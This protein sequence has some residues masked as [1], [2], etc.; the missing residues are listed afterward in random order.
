[1]NINKLHKNTLNNSNEASG[2]YS[3]LHLNTTPHPNHF[4][5]TFPSTLHSNNTRTR[6]NDDDDDVFHLNIPNM[7]HSNT[8][9]FTNDNDIRSTFQT[10]YNTESTFP[11]SFHDMVN[12]HQICLWLYANPNILLLAYNMHL[13]MQTSVANVFNF[14][15]SNFNSSVLA[16]G[17]SRMP[18]QED[19]VN[20]TMIYF[21]ISFCY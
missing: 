18:K 4:N 7:F 19:K 8:S 20:I 16:T 15:S 13:S 21:V 5:N 1:M 2:S 9:F 10:S 3:H 6:S 14:I 11:T 12:V 17:V